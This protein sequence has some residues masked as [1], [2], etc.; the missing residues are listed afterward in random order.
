[1]N[2]PTDF[3]IKSSSDESYHNS[4]F[5]NHRNKSSALGFQIPLS[6]QP[7]LDIIYLPVGE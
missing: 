5:L 3:E 7:R 6:L 1:M 2:Q 4:T